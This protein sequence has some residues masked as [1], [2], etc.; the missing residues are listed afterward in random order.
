MP[1]KRPPEILFAVRSHERGTPRMCARCAE[2]ACEDDLDDCLYCHT[3]NL[4]AACMTGA[5]AHDCAM[6]ARMN[7]RWTLM[8]DA[9]RLSSGRR[10]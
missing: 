10:G 9:R 7:D 8:A 5:T 3:K 6:L 4:C 1:T 2:W